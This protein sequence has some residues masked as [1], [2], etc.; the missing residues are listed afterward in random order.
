MEFC[1]LKIS[2][3]AFQWR[4]LVQFLFQVA[5][6]L[7]ASIENDE[8]SK[9]NEDTSQAKELEQ[10]DSEDDSMESTLESDHIVTSFSEQKKGCDTSVILKYHELFVFCRYSL[11]S[12]IVGV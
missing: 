10:D 3:I 7:K 5:A 11:S 6:D 1:S 2:L 4:V 12:V 8:D 9:D